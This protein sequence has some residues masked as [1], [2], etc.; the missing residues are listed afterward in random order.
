MALL[1]Y[2]DGS[3]RVVVHTGNLIESDWENRTQGLW[4]SPRCP[5][6]GPPADSATGFRKVRGE[7][8]Q[9]APHSGLSFFVKLLLMYILVNLTSVEFTARCATFGFVQATQTVEFDVEICSFIT[10]HSQGPGAIPGSLFRTRTAA[11][12][13][14]N[15]KIQHVGHQ[16]GYFSTFSPSFINFSLVTKGYFICRP[17]VSDAPLPSQHS[18]VGSLSLVFN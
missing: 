17:I 3:L 9:P 5:T 10:I 8:E 11:L 13:R 12:D 7:I 14:Q 4:I 2:E 6:D 1:G 18:P 16:V 15:S